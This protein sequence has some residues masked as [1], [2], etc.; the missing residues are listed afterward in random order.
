MGLTIKIKR[1][2]NNLEYGIGFI[3]WS[4]INKV[5]NFIMWDHKYNS[6]MSVNLNY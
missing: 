3:Y 6:T 4:L 1:D 2:K 5:K